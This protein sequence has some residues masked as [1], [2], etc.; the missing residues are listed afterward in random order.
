MEKEIKYIKNHGDWLLFLPSVMCHRGSYPT[1]GR[2]RL[3][4]INFLRS[5]LSWRECFDE[6]WEINQFRGNWVPSNWPILNN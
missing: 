6:I 4:S 1:R 3:L 2:R 5:N